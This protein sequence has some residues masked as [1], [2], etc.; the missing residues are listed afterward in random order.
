MLSLPLFLAPSA[1]YARVLNK[2]LQ[3]EEWALER[4]SQHSGKSL[5]IS[6][7]G[8]T[9]S[10]TIQAAGKVQPSDPAI[11][12]DVTLTIPA[13]RLAELPAILQARDPAGLTALLHI[14]GDAALA[15]LASDL[16][17]DL[18]WDPEED[19]SRVVGD[20]A[21]IR[22]MRTGK[23]LAQGVQVSAVRLAENVTEFLGEESGLMTAR[24]ALDAHAARLAQLAQR[25]NV[26]DGRMGQLARPAAHHA[27]RKG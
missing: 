24:P 12:P 14:E 26:L 19:L 4:L 3:R 9:S 21:A 6:V 5:R 20:I 8:F 17:R 23:L 22:V 10:L 1:L 13:H 18:R 2:L 7:A 27:A 25:L 16:A 15:Q 11:V